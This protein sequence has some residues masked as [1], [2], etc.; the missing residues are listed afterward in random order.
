MDYSISNWVIVLKDN[1]NNNT[2]RGRVEIWQKKKIQKN[3][4]SL[5]NLWGIK[6]NS[7]CITEV[8]EGE[9]GLRT[10]LKT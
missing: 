8:S 7:V 1:N 2:I 5:R 6:L 4:G 3:E 10:D 9:Q